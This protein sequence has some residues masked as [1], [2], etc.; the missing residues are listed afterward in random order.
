MNNGCDLVTLPPFS[1][2][3]LASLTKKKIKEGK[4]HLKSDHLFMAEMDMSMV[5]PRAVE[6]LESDH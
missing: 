3:V 4:H 1:K 6:L 5:L 2:Q